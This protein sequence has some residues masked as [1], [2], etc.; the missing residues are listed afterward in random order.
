VDAFH[1]A[2][3]AFCDWAENGSIGAEAAHARRAL[4]LLVDLYAAAL[5]LPESPPCGSEVEALHVAQDDWQRLYARFGSLP[6]GYYGVV[7]DPHTVPPDQP[8]VGDL[9]DD[10][11]DIYRDIKNGL[12]LWTAGHQVQAVWHWRHHFGFHWGRRGV[13]AIRA[14]HIWLEQEAEL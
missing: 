1:K 11:A 3:N 12:M 7:Y 5:T 9:A 14:L 2:A 4:C 6:F 10:L 13:D 8:L